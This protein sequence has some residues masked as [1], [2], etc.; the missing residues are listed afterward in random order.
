MQPLDEKELQYQKAQLREN[1]ILK[2]L[3][4]SLAVQA[5]RDPKFPCRLLGVLT[6]ERTRGEFACRCYA[7]PYYKA[8]IYSFQQFDRTENITCPPVMWNGVGSGMGGG[9]NG[10]GNSGVGNSGV[11]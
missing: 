2:V 10:G 8:H 3:L 11:T 7:K 9:T 4:Q 6:R 1:R 5:V